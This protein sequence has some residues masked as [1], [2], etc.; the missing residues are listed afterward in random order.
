MKKFGII[1]DDAD[2][3]IGAWRVVDGNHLE[4]NLEDGHIERII[5]MAETAGEATIKF[6]LDPESIDL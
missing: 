2:Q 3:H 5:Q 6:M 4:L 1:L